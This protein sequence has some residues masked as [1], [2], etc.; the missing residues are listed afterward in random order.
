VHPGRKRAALA[1]A[2]LSDV[3]QWCFLPV[4]SEGALSPFD[5]ALDAVTALVILLVVGFQWRLAVALVVELIPGVDLFPTWTAVV[6]SLPSAGEVA[7][8]PDRLPE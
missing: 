8:T 3:L 5:V 6:L 4:L 2:A 1:V 7:K